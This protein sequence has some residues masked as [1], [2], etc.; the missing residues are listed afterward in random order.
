MLPLPAAANSFMAMTA[1]ITGINLHCEFEDHGLI[2]PVVFYANQ[3]VV[4]LNTLPE[5]KNIAVK[6]FYYCQKYCASITI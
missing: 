5:G 2:M 6:V 3:S 1:A 4:R